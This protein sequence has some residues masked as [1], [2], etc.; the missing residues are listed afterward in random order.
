MQPMT[1]LARPLRVRVQDLASL[2]IYWASLWGL[3]NLSFLICKM[4][5]MGLI[6]PNPPGLFVGIK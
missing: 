2:A 5:P 3:L 6:I 1:Q 4:R